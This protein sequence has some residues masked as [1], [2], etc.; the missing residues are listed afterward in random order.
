[1]RWYWIRRIKRR[2]IEGPYLIY[3]VITMT[4]CLIFLQG[5]EAS[6][7]K[8]NFCLVKYSRSSGLH[9]SPTKQ[10]WLQVHFYLSV[11]EV[12]VFYSIE[13][14]IAGLVKS[15]E[16]YLL[17][18]APFSVV[19]KTNIKATTSNFESVIKTTAC[20]PQLGSTWYRNIVPFT[21]RAKQT[22]ISIHGNY[23]NLARKISA[24]RGEGRKT[25][26]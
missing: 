18:N 10:A 23:L 6:R 19:I 2:K 3:L 17:E 5:K 26:L 14:R 22:W 9:P 13:I 8:D 11:G 24:C 12:A 16:K 7:C 25:L 15:I 20:F 1:M 4:N 21:G